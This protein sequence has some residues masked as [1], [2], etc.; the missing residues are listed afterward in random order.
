MLYLSCCFQV[1]FLAVLLSFFSNTQEVNPGEQGLPLKVEADI[2]FKGVEIVNDNTY[3]IADGIDPLEIELGRM[4]TGLEHFVKVHFKNM[5]D[6]PFKI[7]DIKSSC[8][9]VAAAKRTENVPSKKNGDFYIKIKPQFKESTFSKS[10]T[11]TT[12]AGLVFQVFLKGSFSPKYSLVGDRVELVNAR[13]NSRIRARLKLNELKE[14]IREISLVSVTNFTRLVRLEPDKSKR[15]EWEIELELMESA[16]GVFHT[17]RELRES[18]LIREKGETV[19]SCEVTLAIENGQAVLCKPST[20]SL[21]RS[22]AA[23][24]VEGELLL[25]GKQE[26]LRKKMSLV[27]MTDETEVGQYPLIVSS[28][29]KNFCR[30]S[31]VLPNESKFAGLA[32]Q[33]FIRADGVD[34][35]SIVT[36]QFPKE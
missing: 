18:F 15:G 31:I 10:V 1:A 7:A 13:S 24:M 32:I 26:N 5:L 36:I 17:S 20:V 19:P 2:P 8:G 4:Q 16:S 25:F 22:K 34:V 12:D 14:S 29:S 33:G 6:K 9:C 11:V 23:G 3:L 28:E 30:V 21:T 35:G 27:L